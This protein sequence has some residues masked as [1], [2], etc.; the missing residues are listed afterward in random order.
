MSGGPDIAVGVEVDPIPIGGQTIMKIGRVF[1]SPI[2]LR[3]RTIPLDARVKGTSPYWR[4]ADFRCGKIYGANRRNHEKDENE[5]EA[6]FHYGSP[7]SYDLL[8]SIL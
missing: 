1:I 6:L 8:S 7:L 5:P 3:A 4:I 2:L